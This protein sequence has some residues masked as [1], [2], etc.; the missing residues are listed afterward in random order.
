MTLRMQLR[1][2]GT[3]LARLAALRLMCNTAYFD[4]LQVRRGGSL[5]A[6]VI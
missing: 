5:F 6:I 2:C 4:A 1:A 3:D